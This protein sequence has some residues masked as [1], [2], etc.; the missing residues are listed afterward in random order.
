M[1]IPIQLI[2]PSHTMKAVDSRALIDSGADIS[3]IDWQFVRKHQLPTTKLKTPIRAR[4]ADHS[5]NKN[6][7]IRHTCTLFLNVE[8]IA[9]KITLHVMALGRDNVI[10]GLPWLKS[11]NPTI[12]WKNRTLTID[13]SLDESRDLYTTYVADDERHNSSSGYYKTP[14]RPPKH[15][16]VDAV[17]DAHLFSYL[18]QETESQYIRRAY[19]NRTIYRI[20]RSGS[21]FIPMG[22]PVIARLTQATE[23]AMAAEKSKPKVTL[24]PNTLTSLQSSLRKQPATFL[25]LDLMTMR[26]TSMIPSSQR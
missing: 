19:D 11:T 16:H 2:V 6:G 22:S 23:L 4:N 9:Q 1:Q 7:D 26:S 20:I 21:R 3:C 24:P 25:L 10:L 18:D 17:T 14:A 15:V 8:G 12:D 13:E 5:F